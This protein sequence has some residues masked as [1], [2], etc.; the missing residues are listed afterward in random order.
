ML[1]PP[2]DHNQGVL[3]QTLARHCLAQALAALDPRARVRAFSRNHRAP[4]S[5]REIVVALGKAAAPM[6][7]GWLEGAPEPVETV[8]VRPEGTSALT[9]VP[10]RLREFV[11]GHPEPNE[12]SLQAGVALLDAAR[13]CG[14]DPAHYRLVALLS[15]GGSALAEVPLAGG[16]ER[17][18]EVNRLLLA[19]GAPIGAINCIRKHRSAIKGGRL[20]AAAAGARQLS[21]ILSDVP[22]G[23]WADVASGPTCPDGTTQADYEAAWRHWLPGDPD[24]YP[25]TPQPGDAAFAQAEWHCLADNYDACTALAAA[26][27]AAGFDPVIVDH[28]ADEMEEAEAAAYL[29][30]QWRALHA[31][32][33]RAGLI[34]GG[35]VRVR[36]G[37]HPGR[38]G[39]NQQLALRIALALEGQ[40][41][42]FLSAGT[43]GVD[44]SSDAAG[45]CVDGTTAARIRAAGL[46]PV[47]HL[48]H[49]DAHPALAA[50]GA[51]IHTGPT[52]NNLRDLRLF[53]PDAATGR[54]H[55]P[56]RASAAGERRPAKVNFSPPDDRAFRA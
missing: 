15:G 42:C 13:R 36:L 53:L 49:H 32:Q 41:G 56:V 50:A 19:S 46:D 40:P 18:R 47:A 29:L 17:L 28:A 44:G 12:V 3:P 30:R 9:A 54:R 20:A 1:C 23:A 48:R 6:L 5:P 11:A 16:L 8:L 4:G 43:D 34:A 55:E 7:A 22:H 45:A 24:L 2:P 31:A 35:E 39:R 38:G 52:G 37:S 33:P 14:A 51:L 26:A 25:E 10:P 21:L 27:G